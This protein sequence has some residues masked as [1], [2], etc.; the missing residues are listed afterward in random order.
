MKSL[1]GIEYKNKWVPNEPNELFWE[2][3][4]VGRRITSIQFGEKGR[5]HCMNLDN[6]EKV[7]IDPTTGLFCLK[8]D[9]TEVGDESDED[10]G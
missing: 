10:K 5:I 3:V 8:I 1:Q 9:K 7:Y 2:E 4:F 6:G